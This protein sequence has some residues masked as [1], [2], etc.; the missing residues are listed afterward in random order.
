MN[1]IDVTKKVTS[2]VIVLGTGKIISAITKNNTSPDKLTDKVTMACAAYV[3][4][5]MVADATTKYT[6]A[7]IDELVQWWNENV[8]GKTPELQES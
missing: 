5:M 4:G 1:K 3:L 2:V 8:K 7:K 6:D